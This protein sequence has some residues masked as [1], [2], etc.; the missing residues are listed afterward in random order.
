MSQSDADKE[1]EKSL[2]NKAVDAIIRPPRRHYDVSKLPLYLNCG[3]KQNYVRHPLNFSNARDQKI[4]GSIYLTEGQD[5]MNGGPCIIYMHGNASSQIEGQFLIPNFCPRGIAVYCFDFAGCGESDGDYISL[6]YFETLDINYLM[7]FLHSTFN[8]SPFALWGRSM[9]AA[10]AVLARSQYLKC[11]VVDSTFTSVPDVISDIAKKQKLPSF[12]VPAVL[13]WLKNTVK[14]RAGFDMKD[15]SPLEAGS[16]PD[17]VP[18]IQGHATDDEFI[19]IDQGRQLF[20]A[21]SNPDKVFHHLH[22]GHNG[23]RNA[24]WLTEA[25]KF[26]LSHFGANVGDVKYISYTGMQSQDDEHFKDFDAMMEG[27]RN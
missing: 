10:T 6:G 22:G 27:K 15:V 8:L 21:Y 13:W 17:A 5:I 7:D 16:Q 12:L 24:N 19:P 4:V 1:K 26:V 14:G 3:D 2:V 18:M 20:S 11:I 25:I 9:G 23:R